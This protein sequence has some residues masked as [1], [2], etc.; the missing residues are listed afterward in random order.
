ME[1]KH[2]FL[3]GFMGAGKSTVAGELSRQLDIKQIEM[4]EYIVQEQGMSIND[5]FEKY[6]ETYFRELETKLLTGLKDQERVIVSCGGGVAMR[7]ENVEHMKES[8]TIILLTASPETIFYR[9]KDSHDRP[10]LNGNMSVEFICGLMEK[11]R[12]Y[13]E[14]AADIIIET[15]GKTAAQISEEIIW[16]V[17]CL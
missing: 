1:R 7:S 13:Y 16:K 6:G 17:S 14:A 12:E 11:R 15:D 10:I 8:G 4:D 9:V 5:I 3:I 2:I